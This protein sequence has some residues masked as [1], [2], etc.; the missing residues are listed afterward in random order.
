MK[1]LMLRPVLAVVLQGST[2]LRDAS[3]P[4]YHI[5]ESEGN[6]DGTDMVA[7]G[8]EN[9]GHPDATDQTKDQIR[10]FF[11][12]PGKVTR[13]KLYVQAQID[14]SL[15]AH[16]FGDT[17]V[18]RR[19]TLAAGDNAVANQMSHFINHIG[20][21]DG[22]NGPQQPPPN[23]YYPQE[24]QPIYN[25]PAEPSSFVISLSSTWVW[26]L[27][28]LLAVILAFNIVFMCYMN[29][30]KRRRGRASFN[31]RRRSGYSS[32]KNVDSEDFYD[33]E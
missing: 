12:V 3:V 22:R 26:I 30:S 6:T 2:P 21:G 20:V 16:D 33:S 1:K 32:V 17:D 19:M 15:I 13:D 29:C 23:N 7:E 9:K 25:L 24:P 27:G 5:F 10:F 4:F 28:G 18:V 8:F 14:V 31:R 11:K